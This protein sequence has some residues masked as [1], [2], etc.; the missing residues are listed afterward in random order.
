MIKKF[1]AYNPFVDDL[2]GFD[3][4]EMSYVGPATTFFDIETLQTK[5]ELVEM[6]DR[7]VKFL[8]DKEENDKLNDVKRKFLI[9]RL[10]LMFLYI[11]YHEYFE[12][13]FG[14]GSY[15]YVGKDSDM[16]EILEDEVM[17]AKASKMKNL[18]DNYGFDGGF[19]RYWSFGDSIVFRT[20]K[21]LKKEKK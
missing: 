10:N 5:E 21:R 8:S 9:S 12:K 3:T 19:V 13:R 17:N 6:K 4:P 16:D 14:K 11:D 15:R 2:D 20:N 18:Y 7:L 1:E